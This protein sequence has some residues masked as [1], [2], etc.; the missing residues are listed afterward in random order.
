MN[1]IIPLLSVLVFLSLG[2]LAQVENQVK[3]TDVE[4]LSDSQVKRAKDAVEQSGMT[5]QQAI[6]AARQR[7]A[8]PQQIQQMQERFDRLESQPEDTGEVS[9]PS[10]EAAEEAEKQED[11][12]KSKRRAP[13]GGGSRVFGSY[14]FNSKNLTFEPNSSKQVPLD[15]EIGIGDQFIINIWGNSR[16]NYQLTVNRNGQVSIPDIG[17]IFVAGMTFNKAEEKIKTR[18]YDIYADMQGDKPGTFAQVNLGQFRSIQVNLVGEVRSPGTYNLQATSTVFNALYLSGGPNNIGSFRNIHI[19]RDNKKFKTVDIYKFLIDADISDNINLKN[20]DIIFVPA[21]EKKV[22]VN[23]QFKR[24]ATYELKEG[25]M[26]SDLIK[27]AGGFTDET[28]LYSTQ[29]RRKTQQGK[30]IMDVMPDRFGQTALKDGDVVSNKSILDTFENR[31][32][33]SGSVYRPGDYEWTENM[34]LSDLIIKAD[35]LT[36]DAFKKRGMIIRFNEDLSR[37]TIDFVPSEIMTT[38]EDIFLQPEDQVIIKSHFDLEQRETITVNGEVLNPGTLTYMDGMTVKDALYMANGFKESADSAFIEVARRLSPDEAHKLSDTLMHVFQ[39][40]VARDLAADPNK[41]EFELQPY[42]Q[43]NIRRAPGFREQG[44]VRITGEVLYA[45]TFALQTK[46][47]RIT[48][49]I[50]KAGGLTPQAYPIGA[51]MTRR[52]SELGTERVSIQLQEILDNPS[53]KNN[54]ILRAGDVI[55]IPEE[56]QTVKVVGSV[57]NPFSHTYYDKKSFKDYVDQSGGFDENAK[58]GRAY[59]RYP[60][61][62]TSVTKSFIFRNYPKVEPGC[63]IVVPQKPEREGVDSGELLGYASTVASIAMAFAAIFR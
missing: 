25:E 48:D 53:E 7:G 19:I 9:D 34:R 1:K 46:E 54:L 17:P 36:A 31:V 32:S 12:E 11:I 5:R 44:S 15:Y 39:V 22:T 33:I 51:T 10:E 21:A 56:M 18:L 26:L 29:I 37:R 20:E 40:K 52:T 6:E 27:Y 30:R 23:G 13:V 61:G 49:L 60:D 57:Q 24:N 3:N 4:N 2:L 42:D 28:Y 38:G 50:S 14:L 59:V 62:S 43:V 8:T 47:M 63:V 58:K 55:R 45:G 35:S 41:M 16:Q